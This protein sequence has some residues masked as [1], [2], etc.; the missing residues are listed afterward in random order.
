VMQGLI[1]RGD[2]RLAK[3]LVQV[4]DYGD[5]LGSY[6]RAFKDLKG[7]LPPLSFYVHDDWPVEQPLPWDHIGGPLPKGTLIKHRA[8][9]IAHFP[10]L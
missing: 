10:T 3:L 5:S 4:R 1:A 8:D 9:A 6:K 7:Q 2:R